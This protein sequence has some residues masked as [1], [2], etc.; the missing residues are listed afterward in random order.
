MDSG[1]RLS[2][3]NVIDG[4]MA[5]NSQLLQFLSD[6]LDTK[7][8]QPKYLQTTAAGEAYAAGLRD[9]LEEITKLWVEGKRVSPDISE[10]AQL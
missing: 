5:V 1:I 10:E 4:G 3:L 2:Q 7:V 9:S 8:L 6:I